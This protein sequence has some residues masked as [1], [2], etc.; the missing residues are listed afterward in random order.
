[1]REVKVSSRIKVQSV[2]GFSFVV[3]RLQV[4]ISRLESLGWLFFI[5]RAHVSELLEGWIYTLNVVA[6]LLRVKGCDNESSKGVIGVW[7]MQFA[8]FVNARLLF[9]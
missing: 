3:R 7:H 8:R 1:M 4:V 9:G 6:E 2:S 5:W